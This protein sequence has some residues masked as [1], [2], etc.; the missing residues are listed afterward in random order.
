[1][2]FPSRFISSVIL[3]L[4]TE[5]DLF[6]LITKYVEWIS[7]LGWLRDWACRVDD[8]KLLR[9]ISQLRSLHVNGVQPLILHRGFKS[10]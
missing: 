2:T 8:R 7:E 10:P 5:Q 6:S 1:M 9:L 4:T 3:A